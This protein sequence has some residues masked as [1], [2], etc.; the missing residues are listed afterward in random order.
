MRAHLLLISLLLLAVAAATPAVLL[1][2][3]PLSPDS[4]GGG[5]GFTLACQDDEVLVGVAGR[6]GNG[7]DRVQAVC[8]QV[9]DE[10]AWV[11]TLHKRGAAGG[12]GGTEFEIRCPANKAVSALGGRS[13]QWIDRLTVYCDGLANMTL[14]RASSGDGTIAGSAGTSGGV[15]SSGWGPN[16]CAST[17]PRRPATGLRGL[18]GSY[19][20]RIGVRCESIE[21]LSW[22][23][24][25]GSYGGITSARGG[26]RVR[27]MVGLTGTEGVA[28]TVT[29]S[30][31]HAA[32]PIQSSVTLK[33][34]MSIFIDT[35]PVA[36]KTTAIATA[37]FGDAQKKF[38]LELTP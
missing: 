24:P 25:R 32:L 31:N 13:G 21:R 27:V 5:A 9:S 28:R 30:S 7:I 11:G 23:E 10:G 2:D 22:F 1:E 26:T 19:V 35:R 29:M 14:W 12:S 3:A 37:K 38:Y 4:D 33:D 6:E 17:N 36:A 15:L 18:A 16:K 34:T 8:S 20:D